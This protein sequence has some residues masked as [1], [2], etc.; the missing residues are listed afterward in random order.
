[1]VIIS[2]DGTIEEQ[3]EVLKI[4]NH[5]FKNV[6]TWWALCMTVFFHLSSVTCSIF[7]GSFL[8]LFPSLTFLIIRALP[9]FNMLFYLITNNLY[10]NL[11]GEQGRVFLIFI[12]LFYV[13]TKPTNHTLQILQKIPVSIITFPHKNVTYNNFQCDRSFKS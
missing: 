12:S 6:L 7:S 8:N 13:E 9:S 3:I 4:K 10:S 5:C 2:F 1:M 11:G